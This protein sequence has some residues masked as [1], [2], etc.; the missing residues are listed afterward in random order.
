MVRQ[1]YGEDW[2]RS[3]KLLH[4]H[5]HTNAVSQYH[6]IQLTAARAF[7]RELLEAESS[8]DALPALVWKDFAETINKIVYGIHIKTEQERVDYID[9]P[10]QFLKM[11]S[12]SATPGRFWVDGLHFRAY[13]GTLRSSHT[14]YVHSPVRPGMDAWRKLPDLG[15]EGKRSASQSL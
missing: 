11:L 10:T 4:P 2:R 3:R 8:P 9:I 6:S 7:V 1:P 5:V 12:E 13:I 15:K 14:H